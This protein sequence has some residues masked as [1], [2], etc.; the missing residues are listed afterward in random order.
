MQAALAE[1]P[2]GFGPVFIM[3]AMILFAFT[4]LPGK[5]AVRAIKD[6]YEKRKTG[7]DITFKASD[8]G[9]PHDTDYWK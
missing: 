1:N 2:G 4:T 3:V 5:Y 7:R 8:I 9:L 6:Y